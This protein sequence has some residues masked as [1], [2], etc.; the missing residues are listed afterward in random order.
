MRV[1]YFRTLLCACSGVVMLGFGVSG[2]V[3]AENQPTAEKPGVSLDQQLYGKGS[4]IQITSDEVAAWRKYMVP[5]NIDPT[6]RALLDVMLQVRLF[7]KEARKAG[8][9]KQTNLQ[10]RI[11]FI[12]DKLLADAYAESFL[13]KGLNF[14][15]EALESY[16]LAHFEEFQKPRSFELFRLITQD[17]AVAN[18][19]LGE[20][21]SPGADFSVVVASYS[22]DPATKPKK[23]AMGK[24][25]EERLPASLKEHI[26]ELKA[27]AVLGPF[28]SDGFYFVYYI[29]SVD[30]SK[31]ETLEEARPKIFAKAR[32]LKG[33]EA[34][35]KH[36]DELAVAHSFKWEDWV[37][38]LMKNEP[39]P[40]G[41]R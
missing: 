37:I 14:N 4:D 21:S 34:L 32:E 17:E 35:K 29:K 31:P 25:T 15:D 27:G 28:S 9:D 10:Y 8:L 24:V 2:N 22:C 33:L 26:G 7:A 13:S 1:S 12:E 3:F 36:S 23:G 38:E 41:A 18:Q 30:E 20:A 19:A 6:N 11:S 16:Y 39:S 5:P 40:V